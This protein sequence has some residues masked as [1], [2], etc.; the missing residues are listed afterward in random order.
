MYMFL[1]VYDN[2]ELYWRKEKYLYTDFNLQT[3]VS[4]AAVFGSMFEQ[5]Q[6]NMFIHL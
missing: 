5:N 4:V 1:L 2:E 3:L 6:L